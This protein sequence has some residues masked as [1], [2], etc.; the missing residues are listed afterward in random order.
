MIMFSDATGA[1][2]VANSWRTD[3]RP[4]LSRC[5]RLA[6]ECRQGM[7]C[8]AAMVSNRLSALRKYAGLLR[9][10]SMESRHR[11]WSFGKDV[12]ADLSKNAR[13]FATEEGAAS[14]PVSICA[15]GQSLLRGF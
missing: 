10:T 5:L 1:L 7:I 15:S 13:Y 2:E 6:C 4:C 9:F 12:T 11:H 14:T 8:R 3:P